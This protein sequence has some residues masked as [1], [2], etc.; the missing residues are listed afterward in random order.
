[1]TPERQSIPY[2]RE[3]A[4]R[5]QADLLLVYASGSVTYEK[6][7]FLSPNVTKARCTVEAILLDVRTGLV[8]FTSVATQ[9]Y[10]AKKTS[11]DMTFAETIARGRAQAERVALGE[12]ADSVVAFLAEAP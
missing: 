5:C 7:R 11:E 4:A 6:Y 3:A 12:I 10:E 9:E 1:L 8:P 2:L